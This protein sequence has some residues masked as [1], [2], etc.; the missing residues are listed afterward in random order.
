MDG[1]LVVTTGNSGLD[2][3]FTKN[4]GTV[5]QGHLLY[6]AELSILCYLQL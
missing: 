2:G 4:L 6:G 1:F 5:P 3:A